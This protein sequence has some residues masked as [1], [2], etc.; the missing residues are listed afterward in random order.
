MRIA[1][2]SDPHIT[3]PQRL[4]HGFVDT[5]AALRRAVAHLQGLPQQPDLVLLTGDLVDDLLPEAYERLRALLAP[6]TI[7]V[8]V[9][10]GNHDDRALLR[11]AFAADGYLPEHG[12]FLHYVL[13]DAPLRLI[14]LDTQRFGE[15]GG[16]LCEARLQWLAE[17]LEEGAERPTLL[18]MHHPPFPTGLPVDRY[19]FPGAEALGVLLEQHRQ[20]QR[21]VAG[22]V[23][24][25]VQALWHGVPASTCSATAFQFGLD[26]DRPR[27][28]IALEPP[29]LHLHTWQPE[30]GVVTHTSPIGDYPVR[31]IAR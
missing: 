21:I 16:E 28:R 1:Q 4:S 30:T 7:P 13:E 24:R 6:L 5:A 29:V 27:S 25:A 18:F 8:Y 20:V 23:H 19:G 22:H 10:P 11:A 26:L 12:P 31:E 3:V 9:I 14:G 17:R 15:V 2:L